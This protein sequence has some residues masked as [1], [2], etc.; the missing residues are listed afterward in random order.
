MLLLQ[1]DHLLLV[2]LVSVLLTFQDQP[3]RPANRQG[4]CLGLSHLGPGLAWGPMARGEPLRLTSALGILP[5]GVVAPW[6]PLRFDLPKQ[7]PC[8]QAAVIPTLDQRVFVRTQ[9][10]APP[11]AALLAFGKGGLLQAAKHRGSVDPQLPRD[12]VCRPVLAAQL[13]DVLVEGHAPRPALIGPFLPRWGARGRWHRHHDRTVVTRDPLLALRLI[14][15][16]EVLVMGGENLF[17]SGRHVLHH[18]EAVRNLHRIGCPL[19]NTG[20]RRVR[21]VTGHHVDFGM[22]LEPIRH[23]VGQAVLEHVNGAAALEIDHDGA[24]AMA[25]APGPVVNANDVWRWI[26]WRGQTSH[27]PEYGVATARH[28]LAGQLPGTGRAPEG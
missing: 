28:A 23:R 22:R 1:L 2:I 25:F 12:V 20:C 11:A 16:F 6:V 27:P 18:M 24:V 15:R 5:H 4:R 8:G 9:H 3:G 19:P 7:A 14:E 10:A 21:A 13:P 17:E 26:G